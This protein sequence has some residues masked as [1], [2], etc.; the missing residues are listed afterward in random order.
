MHHLFFRHYSATAV[1][2]LQQTQKLYTVYI[3]SIP[4]FRH[5]DLYNFIRKIIRRKK[6]YAARI[7]DKLTFKSVKPFIIYNG[8]LRLAVWLEWHQTREGGDKEI[9]KKWQYTCALCNG[10][11]NIGHVLNSCGCDALHVIFPHTIFRALFRSIPLFFA[12]FLSFSIPLPFLSPSSPPLSLCRWMSV[13]VCMNCI[14]IWIKYIVCSS[15][16]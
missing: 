16:V 1:Y 3:Q 4:H 12:V 2:M 9:E 13:S 7:S 11:W 8:S 5:I 6:K 10:S 14:W 15:Y